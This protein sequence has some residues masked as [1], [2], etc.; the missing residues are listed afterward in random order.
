ML[1]IHLVRIELSA[2]GLPLIL[3][4]RIACVFLHFCLPWGTLMKLQSQ[5][6]IY[7]SKTGRRLKLLVVE[8][9]EADG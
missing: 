1:G 2:H 5:Y 7:T 6:N 3:L 4:T 9:R 8:S